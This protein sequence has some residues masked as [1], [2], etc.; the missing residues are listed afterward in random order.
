M[1]MALSGKEAVGERYQLESMRHAQQMTWK[2]IDQIARVITPGMRES[3]A[4]SLG[5]QGWRPRGPGSMPEYRPVDS[6]NPDRPSRASLRRV[7]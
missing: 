7:L 6:G 2:A 1:T 5:K 4:Q 3:E